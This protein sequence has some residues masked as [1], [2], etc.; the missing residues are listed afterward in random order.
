MERMAK[1]RNPLVHHYGEIDA[2][3]VVSI[4]HNRLIDFLRYRDAILS[5][6]KQ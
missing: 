1:F 4:L 5:S 6:I 3:I 2:S